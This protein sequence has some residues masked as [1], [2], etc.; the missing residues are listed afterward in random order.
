MACT[1]K[2]CTE[3]ETHVASVEGVKTIQHCQRYIYMYNKCMRQVNSIVH[4]D[5][6]PSSSAHLLHKTSF[7]KSR[8][9]PRRHTQAM[10]L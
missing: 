4:A 7:H 3:L 10:N 6:V 5:R 1:I 8:I 2:I 9:K